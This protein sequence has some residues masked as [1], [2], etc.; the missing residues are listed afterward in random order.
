MIW[1]ALLC[2]QPILTLAISFLRLFHFEIVVFFLNVIEI[3]AH[4]GQGQGVDG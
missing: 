2:M 4:T 1:V 3:V